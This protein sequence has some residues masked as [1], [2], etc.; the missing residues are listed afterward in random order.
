[1]T[2]L[3]TSA[4]AARAVASSCL[5]ASNRHLVNVAELGPVRAG[6]TTAASS[7]AG[8]AKA[9]IIA[10][11]ASSFSANGHGHAL[12]AVARL[13]AREHAV[14]HREVAA[15]EISTLGSILD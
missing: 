6:S 12:A 7:T 9:A 13:G 3:Q 5:A 4:T 2:L 14:I 1:M 10:V 11:Y 8:T 15:D